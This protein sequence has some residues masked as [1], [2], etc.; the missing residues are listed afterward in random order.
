MSDLQPPIHPILIFQNLHDGDEF[1]MDVV[2]TG[3]SVEIPIKIHTSA[4]VLDF[5]LAHAPFSVSLQDVMVIILKR[6]QDQN[7]LA[8]SEWATFINQGKAQCTIEEAMVE[9]A[10]DTTLEVRRKTWLNDVVPLVAPRVEVQTDETWMLPERGQM[11]STAGLHGNIKRHRWAHA[12]DYALLD[13]K[14][15]TDVLHKHPH[16]TTGQPKGFC[17]ARGRGVLLGVLIEAGNQH[18]CSSLRD[19]SYKPGYDTR[20]CMREQ[21]PTLTQ[22][23]KSGIQPLLKPK[24]THPKKRKMRKC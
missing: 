18:E 23:R 4:L 10:A 14:S 20:V 15:G 8:P 19:A 24:E 12:I 6:S 3:G 16:H 22:M 13:R 1:A 5:F 11:T 7:F 2:T 17:G 21:S 9:F